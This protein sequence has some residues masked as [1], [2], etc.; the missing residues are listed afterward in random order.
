PSAVAPSSRAA[1][2][3]GWCDPSGQMGWFEGE[4][5]RGVEAV[6][7]AGDVAGRGEAGG[8]AGGAQ[9]DGPGA[10]IAAGDELGDGGDP[11]RGSVGRGPLQVDDRADGASDEPPDDVEAGAWRR[12]GHGLETGWH[13]LGAAGMEGGHENAVTARGGLP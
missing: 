2:G 10:T 5:D 8:G 9:G 12:Q 3:A 4:E 6:G 13:L 1:P 7:P 11:A